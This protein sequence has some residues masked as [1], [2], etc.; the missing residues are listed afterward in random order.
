MPCVTFK[1]KVYAVEFYEIQQVINIQGSCY[2]LFEQWNEN[3]FEKWHVKIIEVFQVYWKH[4]PN[5][6]LGHSVLHF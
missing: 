2:S 6:D 4:F 1:F 3:Y 5:M